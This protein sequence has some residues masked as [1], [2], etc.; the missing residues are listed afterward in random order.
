MDAAEEAL[1]IKFEFA[2]DELERLKAYVAKKCGV[3]GRRKKERNERVAAIYFDTEDFSLEDAGVALRFDNG[4]RHLQ[5]VEGPNGAAYRFFEHVIWQRPVDGDQPN[6]EALAYEERPEPLTGKTL[7][8]L[9]QVFKGNAERTL[10]TVLEAEYEIDLTVADGKVDIGERS[11]AYAEI[12]FHL[13]RGEAAE[14]FSQVWALDEVVPLR[15]STQTEDMRGYALLRDKPDKAVKCATIHLERGMGSDQAFRVIAHSCIQYIALNER[16]ISPNN[17]ESLHQMRIG[18]RRLRTALSL[19][20]RTVNDTQIETVKTELKWITGILGQARDIDVFLSDVMLP[21]RKQYHEEPGLL[22][23]HRTYAAQR[24]KAYERVAQATNSV[25]YRSLM[26]ELAAW[27]EA[28]PWANNQ[29]EEARLERAQPV[30]IFAAAELTRRRRKVKKK[31]ERLKK[32]DPDERHGLRIQVKRLRY[33]SEFFMTL[34]PG[35]KRKKRVMLANLKDLQEA[36][37]D[38]NDIA[39]RAGLKA[40][41][42]TGKAKRS[43]NARDQHRAFAA[44]LIIGHQKARVETLMKMAQRSFREFAE[45]K[46]FWKDADPEEPRHGIELRTREVPS[47]AHFSVITGGAA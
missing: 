4:A 32:L 35:K 28:G 27:V 41:V 20:G 10:Y 33:A 13:K 45:A 30:A 44:G 23:L 12:E 47:P 39:V 5:L 19:F 9:K 7:E 24:T 17:A 8:S 15:L 25:R 37:G 14:L 3:D 31:G 6:F 2:P 11:S 46:P 16:A 29:N 26:L 36:L 42:V 38:V 1:K 43:N 34:F 22:S 21:L 40:E 18:L